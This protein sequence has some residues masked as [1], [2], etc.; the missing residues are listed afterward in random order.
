MIR[1]ASWSICRFNHHTRTATRIR[2]VI[3]FHLFSIPPPC[4]LHRPEPEQN[5]S[6]SDAKV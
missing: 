3:P 5:L 4:Q 2:W 6:N 1:A